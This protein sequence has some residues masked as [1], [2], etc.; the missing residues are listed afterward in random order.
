MET[1]VRRGGTAVVETAV[2]R[3]GAEPV[4]GEVPT[5]EPSRRSRS[6]RTISRACLRSSP[7]QRVLLH[8]A[9]DPNAARHGLLLA[10]EQRTHRHHPFA[11]VA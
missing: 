6:A 5:R 10:I 7:V 2:C 8:E 1:I 4:V 3:Q 9:V 11:A